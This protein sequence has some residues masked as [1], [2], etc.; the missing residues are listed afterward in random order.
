MSSA[1]HLHGKKNHKTS[2]KKKPLNWCDLKM[3]IFINTKM[4]KHN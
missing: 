3:A 1:T 2:K 4:K